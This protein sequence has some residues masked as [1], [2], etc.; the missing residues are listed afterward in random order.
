[1]VGS[2]ELFGFI[3]L[4]LSL[5][6]L[7]GS[8]PSPSEELVLLVV[9]VGSEPGCLGLAE[10]SVEPSF[11]PVDPTS[12]PF[13]GEVSEAEV[14]VGGS[15]RGCHLQGSCGPIAWDRVLDALG[16]FGDLQGDPLRDNTPR[17][18]SSGGSPRVSL[19]KVH[20]SSVDVQQRSAQQT[21]VP[22]PGNSPRRKERRRR[23]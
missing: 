17:L 8:L 19:R 11:E 21:L 13:G 10:G 1:M 2:A 5:L 12:G 9:E 7:G 20:V 14:H 3:R 18:G 15:E 16:A 22:F 6:L 23:R 4:E